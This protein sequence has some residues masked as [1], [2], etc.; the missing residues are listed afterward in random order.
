MVVHSLGRSVH[1]GFFMNLG[2]AGK[3]A[4]SPTVLTL[5]YTVKSLVSRCGC[6]QEG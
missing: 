5:V 4:A 6:I 3:L 1:T 2:K